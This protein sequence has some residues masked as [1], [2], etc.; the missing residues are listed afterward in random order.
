MHSVTMSFSFL[1]KD[2]LF[3]GHQISGFESNFIKS[4]H[5]PQQGDF[6]LPE[7]VVANMIAYIVPIV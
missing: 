5:F 6:K 1:G 2:G 7:R 4:S 3:K